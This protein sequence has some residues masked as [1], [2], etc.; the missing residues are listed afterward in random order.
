MVSVRWRPSSWMQFSSLFFLNRPWHWP[1]TDDRS[2]EFP[3][4]WFPSN[5][6]AYRVCEC[7]HAIS[8]TP[9]GK[10]HRLKDRESEGATARLRNGKWGARETCFEQCSLMRRWTGQVSITTEVANPEEK[11]ADHL[12]PSANLLSTTHSKDI[13]FPWVTLYFGKHCQLTE[14]RSKCH[15]SPDR[16]FPTSVHGNYSSLLVWG[17]KGEG[18]SGHTICG[19]RVWTIQT[20]H[21]T[22]TSTTNVRLAKNQ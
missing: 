3:D 6:S 11:N 9:K 20:P 21:F 17:R 13:R 19:V 16:R 1:T 15:C 18:E 2:D 10:N 12:A 22:L 8:N 4:G 5:Q 7:K 14:L